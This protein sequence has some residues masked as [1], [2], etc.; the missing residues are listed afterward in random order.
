[1]SRGAAAETTAKPCRRRET[2]GVRRAVPMAIARAWLLQ[3]E[4][5]QR[6]GSY[7]GRGNEIVNAR[8]GT[9]LHPPGAERQ[10]CRRHF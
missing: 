4:Q 7:G 5:P 8:D 9:G 10:A 2:S 1:M 6:R 3:P